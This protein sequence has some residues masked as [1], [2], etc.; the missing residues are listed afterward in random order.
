MEQKWLRYLPEVP[1]WLSDK[2]SACQCRRHEFHLWVEK[3]PLEKKMATHSSKSL[4]ER[5][6][7]SYGPWGLKSSTRLKRLN[8]WI[9][10][11]GSYELGKL[12]P[13][14]KFLTIRPSPVRSSEWFQKV[15]LTSIE[16]IAVFLIRN[17][18]R[19]TQRMLLS[20]QPINSGGP[21]LGSWGGSWGRS[22]EVKRIRG[23][24]LGRNTRPQFCSSFPARVAGPLGPW[25]WEI[26]PPQ[27]E[28]LT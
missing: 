10:C 25:R 21:P 8:N 16:W 13:Q 5:R 20:R 22:Q 28:I 18:W 14:S 17:P 9:I 4:G 7:A 27:P 19:P 2:E 6:L 11:S 3:I 12:I 15:N 1:W 23:V 24:H 26:S